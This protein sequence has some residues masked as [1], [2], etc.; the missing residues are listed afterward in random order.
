VALAAS[1]RLQKHLLKLKTTT[2]APTTL[3]NAVL[4]YQLAKHTDEKQ[5]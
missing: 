4:K 3:M 2:K 5:P 1:R